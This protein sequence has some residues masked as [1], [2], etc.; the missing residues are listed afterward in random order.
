MALFVNGWCWRRERC[1]LLGGANVKGWRI[2]GKMGS[3]GEGTAD[4]KSI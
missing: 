4:E 2:K 3:M 1:E